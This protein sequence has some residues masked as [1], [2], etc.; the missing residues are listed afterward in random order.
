[1]RSDTTTS[2]AD[3]DFIDLRSDVKTRPTGAMLRAIST[4]PLGDDQAREDPTVIALEERICQLT[5]QPEA[6]FVPSSTM[7]NQLALMCR[8]RPGQ[9]VLAENGSHIFRYEAGGPAALAGAVM[10]G[11]PGLNGVID[12][13][14]LRQTAVLSR[15]EHRPLT[16]MVVI[17]NTHNV[18]GGRV[19]PTAALEAV[20]DTCDDLGLAV[21]ID[22]ARIFN[23]SVALGV[24][25]AEITRRAES[26]SI[27]FSKGLGCPA[28][29]VLAGS[30]EALDGVRRMRQMMGGSMRQSGVLAAAALYALDHHVD[31][32]ADDHR[33]ARHLA[34]GL[35]Q[36]GLTVDLAQ[37][38]S[39][40]VFLDVSSLGLRV[41]EAIAHLAAQGVGWS[42][43]HHPGVL[44][45][46][47]HL[48]VRAEQIPVAI[49][50]TVA[51]LAATGT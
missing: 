5:G 3:G 32:L 18:S 36:A 20:H 6:I 10:T 30:E 17:E 41:D 46:V 27:C 23:A 15:S 45:A 11:L 1:M 38:E 48:D 24:P 19:W 8:L 12:P 14:D 44:R 31:R 40:F 50:R 4:A 25:L 39:N 49:D 35:Q 34:T 43:T 13:R 16:R 9:E 37:V 26:L 21:H 28:G 7:A 2:R 29:A 51:A 33:S 22:G 47:T 42:A